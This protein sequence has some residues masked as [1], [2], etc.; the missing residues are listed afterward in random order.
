MDCIEHE[1]LDVA[2]IAKKIQELEAKIKKIEKFLL[3]EFPFLFAS[4]Q[5]YEP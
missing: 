3:L 4:T 1:D 2:P 5:G